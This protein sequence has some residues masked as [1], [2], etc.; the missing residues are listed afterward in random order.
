MAYER[1]ARTAF[2]GK[3]LE[4]SEMF[5]V[6]FGQRVFRGQPNRIVQVQE[7]QESTGGGKQAREPIALVPAGGA[8]GGSIVIGWI[9]VGENKAEMRA[10]H[11][12][13]E[14]HRQRHGPNSQVDLDKGEYE[15]FLNDVRAFFAEEEM[16]TRI[17]DEIPAAPT[18]KQGAGAPARGSS[19]GGMGMGAVV[20]FAVLAIV[21]GLAIGYLLF[22]P[23]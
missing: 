12:L 18:R 10:Y 22:A 3:A 13:A 21:I 23:K 15:S 1:D 6:K 5:T 2:A 9:N 16:P 17:V 14:M 19:G 20:F 11:V 7:P 4:L 8:S